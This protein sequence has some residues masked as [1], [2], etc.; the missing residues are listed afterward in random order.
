MI[1]DSELPDMHTALLSLRQWRIIVSALAE[2]EDEESQSLA[3][4]LLFF[5]LPPTGDS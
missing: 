5:I 4:D 1:P 2:S 3:Q